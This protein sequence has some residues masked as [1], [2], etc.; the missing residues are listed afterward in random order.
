MNN[1]IDLAESGLKVTE[2]AIKER[3]AV[4]EALFQRKVAMVAAQAYMQRLRQIVNALA[5]KRDALISLGAHIREEKR[6]LDMH[7]NEEPG[8]PRRSRLNDD[9]GNTGSSNPEEE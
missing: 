1:R 8:G 6:S 5:A 9:I 4:D 7:I 2:N 3:V